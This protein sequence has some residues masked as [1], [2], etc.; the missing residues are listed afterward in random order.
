MTISRH[1]FSSIKLENSYTLGTKKEKKKKN[2]SSYTKNN[3]ST[4]ID[5]DFTEPLDFESFYYTMLHAYNDNLLSS[6]TLGPNKPLGQHF[7][8]LY[9]RSNRIAHSICILTTSHLKRQPSLSR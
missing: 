5:T 4:F 7:L 6:Y 1:G 8:Y 9:D 3:V 2:N